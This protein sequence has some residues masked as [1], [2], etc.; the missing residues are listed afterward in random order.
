[1]QKKHF[2]G[3]LLRAHL[4]IKNFEGKSKNYTW[5]TRVGVNAALMILRKQR[6]RSEGLFDPESDNR[7]ESIAFEV[8]DSASNPE[9]A[10]DLNQRQLKT[11]RAIRRLSPH[12]RAAIRTQ[13]ARGWSIREIS[14]ALNNSEAAVKS[15]ILSTSPAFD[16]TRSHRFGTPEKRICRERGKENR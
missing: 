13:I 5:L 10:Y 7:G 15:L 16:G 2:R 8:G 9:E 3:T 11:L 12:L 14:R 1:M 4:A 6:L